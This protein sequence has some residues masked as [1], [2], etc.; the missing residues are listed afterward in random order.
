MANRKHRFLPMRG[1][2]LRLCFG[3][4]PSAPSQEPHPINDLFFLCPNTL[5]V[6]P[7]IA[8]CVCMYSD[9]TLFTKANGEPDLAKGP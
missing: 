2:S 5:N 6:I 4:H 1:Q 3:F 7:S 9:N 8:I